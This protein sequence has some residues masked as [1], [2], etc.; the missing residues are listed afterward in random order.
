MGVPLA[1]AVAVSVAVG[2]MVGVSVM[3]GVGV[4][5]GVEAGSKI[6]VKMAWAH[7][8]TEVSMH[9]AISAA[10]VPQPPRAARVASL[11]F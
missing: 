5:L 6:P 10:V 2:V 4:G 3:V 11:H 1:V 9:S 7:W 8:V